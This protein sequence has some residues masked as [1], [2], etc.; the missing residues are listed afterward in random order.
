LSRLTADH[1][2][3]IE[4]ILGRPLAGEDREEFK[5]LTAVPAGVLEVARRIA[6]ETRTL[7]V[8]Y[9]VHLVPDTRLSLAGTFL[10]DV[11]EGGMDPEQWRARIPSGS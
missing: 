8:K 11:V 4:E 2:Q 6:A 7:A 10:E 5:H 9:L 1:V 3:R